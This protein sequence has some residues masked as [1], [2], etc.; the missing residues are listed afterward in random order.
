L[1]GKNSSN[2]KTIPPFAAAHLTVKTTLFTSKPQ[3][4]Q[5]AAVTG[6]GS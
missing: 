1:K 6:A 5:A 4:S 3:A 2:T